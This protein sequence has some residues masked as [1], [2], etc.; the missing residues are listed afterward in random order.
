[1]ARAK[2]FEVRLVHD[3]QGYMLKSFDV[4]LGR[5]KMRGL[6]G[7][8]LEDAVCSEVRRT[9]PDIDGKYPDATWRVIHK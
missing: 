1:M 7:L 5:K 8:D 3:E 6:R 4:T 9:H 2:R